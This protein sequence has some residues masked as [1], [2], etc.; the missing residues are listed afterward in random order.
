MEKEEE[1]VIGNKV[2]KIRSVVN[3]RYFKTV[4]EKV[5]G[6]KGPS[7]KLIGLAGWKN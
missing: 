5:S 6:E 7:N 3:G 1:K 4:I 2:N